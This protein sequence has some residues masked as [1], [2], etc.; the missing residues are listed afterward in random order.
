MNDRHV[1]LRNRL[2]LGFTGSRKGM[3]DDQKAAVFLD[4]R[5]R[6]DYFFCMDWVVVHGDCV[7]ADAEFDSICR[8]LDFDRYKR[9]GKG[10]RKYRAN[11]SARYLSVPRPYLERNRA[12]VMDS[13]EMI[14]APNTMRNVVRSGTWAT[15]RYAVTAEMPIMVYLPDGSSRAGVELV[16]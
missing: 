8:T 3:T 4:M 2:V 13:D 7:G 6:L 10:P 11:T 12:I 9:P 15:I 5:H 1:L 14:A 16:G